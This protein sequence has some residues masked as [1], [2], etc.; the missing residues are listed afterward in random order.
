MI[1]ATANGGVSSPASGVPRAILPWRDNSSNRSIG[2]G[3]HTHLYRMNEAGSLLDITPTGFTVGDANASVRTG[4]GAGPYGMY[5][6]GTPRPDNGVYFEATFWTLDTW[7]EHLVGVQSKDGRIWIWEGSGL[8]TQLLNA[9]TACR[10][11]IVTEERFM[12]ALGASSNP[13][14]VQWSDFQENEVW[15]PTALN[16]AGAEE[17][18]TPGQLMCG[19]R[20]GGVV[21]ILSDVDAH[22][23]RYVGY[24]GVYE[25][26]RVGTACG[27]ISQGAVA[28]IDQTAVWMGRDSFH[29]Y[30]GGTVRLDCSVADYVFGRLNDQQRSKV[31][32]FALASHSEVWWMYPSDD[33]LE[34]DSYVAWNYREN[35]WTTGSLSRTCGAGRGTFANVLMMDPQ[36]YV[37][38]HEYGFS[39]GG[40]VPFV[41][42][43]PIELGE[44]DRHMQVNKVI[45]D[46]TDGSLQLVITS[47]EY[48]TGPEAVSPTYTLTNPT[49]VRASGRSARL[50][51]TSA[52]SADW[53]LGKTRLEVRPRGRRV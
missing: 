2:I 14:L 41:E 1:R 39:Y 51:F 42:T 6:Y 20:V 52:S 21:L 38:E 8:A 16:Q 9:P 37:Y 28:V 12:M 4:Y 15:T 17:L 3:T 44:G 45:P 5:A 32:A 53:R 10:A 18:Q 31:S 46:Q 29:L 43:G 35:H 50:R 22:V 7:G 47:S 24:P 30:N 49:S 13:R 48:P 33:G 11:V 19:A 25:F 26:Q 27:A 23:A 40:A 36:G 34:C